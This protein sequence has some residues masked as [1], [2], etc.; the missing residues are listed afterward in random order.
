V[1]SVPAILLSCNTEQRF[2]DEELRAKSRVMAQEL[3]IVDTHIDVPYRLAEHKEDISTRTKGGDFDYVRAKEGGLDAPFMSIYV[4]A[5][6][7]QNG[8]RAFADSLIAMVEGFRSSWPDKF[9]LARS[10][11]DVYANTAAGKISLPM[12]MENG[13]PL[14]GN[15]Q[16]LKYFHDRGIC[17]ITLAHS[18]NN[19]I[20]D[21]SYDEERK[22]N[23]LSPFGREVV[24]EMN[25]LGI[26]VDVSHI[27]DSA[28]Y[29]VIR[30]SKAPVIASHS[31]CRHFTPGWE[32][33]MSDEMIQLLASRGGVIQINFGSSFLTDELRKKWDIG[34]DEIG[35]ILAERKLGWSDEAAQPI[36]RKYREEHDIGYADITDVVIHIDHVVK[37][38]GVDYVGFGSDFDGVGD[39]LPTGLKDVSMYPNLIYELLKRGYSTRDIEKICGGNLLRVWS[40]VEQL[41][42]DLSTA[43]A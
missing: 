6:Y 11:T 9:A 4:P 8:A 22:W 37:L 31:S 7:E 2:A 10:V 30:R 32:R 38:V 13:A 18:K 27:S 26:M 15:I 3:I 19:H 23:G 40:Q 41:A 34:W 43:G 24:A 14:E 1:L 16:N 25:R 39:S 33:N 5:S 35:G 42:R 20:S 21:S 12:G 28:F 36:I 17:Y 29:Q